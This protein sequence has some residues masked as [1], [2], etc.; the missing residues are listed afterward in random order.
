M[1]VLRTPVQLRGV[2][3]TTVGTFIINKDETIPFVLELLPLARPLHASFDPTAALH[4]TE[5]FWQEWSAQVPARRSVVGRRAAFDDH[6]Q[7]A[8]LCADRRHG[9]GADHVAAGAA[10]RRAQLGLSLLLAARRHAGSARRHECR[11]FRGSA[12]VARMAV[13]RGRRQS[14]PIADHVRHRR[15]AAADRMDRALAARLRKLRAGA[16]RQRR[17][18]PAPAR[19]VRRDHGRPS[20]GAPPRAVDQRIG[21][22][23]ATRLPRPS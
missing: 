2:D 21:M 13:A 8:D 20:S 22:A 16:D 5:T 15:R 19:R 23:R 9:R 17:P 6:A 3:M 7:G 14:G 11:L 1:M 18:Q 12:G 4:D 10:R